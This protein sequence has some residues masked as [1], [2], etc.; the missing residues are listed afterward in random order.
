M[1]KAVE[2]G[3]RSTQKNDGLLIFHFF[4]VWR[5]EIENPRGSHVTEEGKGNKIDQVFYSFLCYG[6]SILTHISAQ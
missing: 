5:K 1:F 6:I 2:I 3:T 4:R